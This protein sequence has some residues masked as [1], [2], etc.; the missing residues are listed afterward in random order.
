MKNISII[1]TFIVVFVIFSISC[2]NRVKT[3]Q[4][5][6]IEEIIV[7]DK[8]KSQILFAGLI[9]NDSVFI[10]SDTIEFDWQRNLIIYLGD[11]ILY[12]DNG[13]SI[14]LINSSNVKII[15]LAFQKI[16][17][18]LITEKMLPEEDQWVIFKVYNQQV[19]L[20]YHWVYEDLLE[21]IDNDGFFEVGGRGLIESVCMGCDSCYYGPFEIYKL[22]ETFEFDTVL[23]KKLTKELYGIFL[24]F[25]NYNYDTVLYCK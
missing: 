8:Q 10:K 2:S 22:N 13:K 5:E 12:K 11:K 6:A 14:Y 18:I 21:D 1:Q 25:D 19:E 17:Y 3:I 20:I 16:A 23:S 4:T 24:E 7:L 9:G 15:Q